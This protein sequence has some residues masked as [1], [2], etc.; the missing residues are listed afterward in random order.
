MRPSSTM[1]V[2]SCSVP[3]GSTGMIQRASMRRSTARGSADDIAAVYPNKKPRDVRGFLRRLRE[4]L[5]SVH[6]AFALDFDFHAT[7][8]CKASDQRL[9]RFLIANHTGYRLR[10]AHA[11]R[12]DLVTRNAL[13]HQ[14]IAD[15]I[16]ATLGQPLVVALRAD[17]IGMA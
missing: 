16:G 8:G 2:C 5:V 7:V 1:S 12:F 14:V 6:H 10:L 11:E 4:S 3:A 15:G 17:A 9:Q 13:A